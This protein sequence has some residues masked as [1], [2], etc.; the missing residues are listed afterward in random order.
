[1]TV[2]THK[3]STA[4]MPNLEGYCTTDEAATKLGFH[5][6]HIRRMIRRGDLE[7]QRVGYMIFVSAKSIKAYQEKTKGFS[8]HSPHKREK[9]SK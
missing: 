5:V 4:T 6:N 3:L 8:K 7:V 2:F 1:M 9:L